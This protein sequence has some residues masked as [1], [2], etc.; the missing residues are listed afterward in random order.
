MVGR[1]TI[2]LAHR[3][4]S[5]IDCD[6]IIVLDDGEVVETGIHRDLISRD[7]TYSALMRDQA[8]QSG[9]EHEI[10]EVVTSVDNSKIDKL[11]NISGGAKIP[12]TEGV[13]K[14]EGLNW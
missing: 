12:E 7:N 11:E 8:M 1:T 5:I 10:K 14:A 6:R 2:N 9:S 4:S 3:L 13:I